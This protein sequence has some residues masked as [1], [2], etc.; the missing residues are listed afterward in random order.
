MVLSTFL[1][2]SFT[3]A[4]MGGLLIGLAS[5]LLLASL[6]RVAG[7][8]DITTGALAPIPGAPVA[9]RVWRVAFLTG[10]IVMGACATALLHPPAIATRP[11]TLLIVAGLL[12]G[13][14]T[15]LGSGCTSGHGVCGL[16]RRS[17]RS[18]VATLVFMGT[19]AATVF[20]VKLLTNTPA[21]A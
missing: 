20:I 14:G 10:L 4:A 5:W 15:V 6:G 18:L 3:Q 8:T 7:I 19:G 17:K 13:F 21:G 12:V 2:H 11:L 1:A 9:E 16:G